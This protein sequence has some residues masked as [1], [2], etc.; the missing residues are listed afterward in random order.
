M[1]TQGGWK[2]VTKALHAAGIVV[3]SGL[4]CVSTQAQEYPARPI[5][6][7]SAT[8]PGGGGDT[9][10][11]YFARKMEPLAKQPV[12]VENKVG[13]GGLIG[14]RAAIAAKP[15]GY[16]LL[17]HASSS[18]IGNAYVVRDSGYDPARDLTPI[19]P[20]ARAVFVLLVGSKSPVKSVADLTALL[21]EKKGAGT[22]ASPNNATA[23]STEL[24]MQAAGVDAVRVNY[25]AVTTAIVDVVAGEVDFAFADLSLAVSQAKG[26][27]VRLLAVSSRQRAAADPSIPTMIEAGFPGFEYSVF[28]GAWAPAKT[29]E[30][31]IDKLAGWFQQV[32]A[33]DETKGALVNLGFEHLSGSSDL[34]A[35]MVRDDAQRWS[36]LTRSGRIKQQ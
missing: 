25:K 31:V 16:T 3:A 4:G 18:I 17:I 33:T 29:P 14:V 8:A 22:Y 32:L 9:L 6:I 21:K 5:H 11:R 28:F 34:L 1:M 30:P 35:Q 20:L 36:E 27:R 15:D 10:V 24:Y 12:V 13:V 7:I 23:V 19:S 26:G 2:S